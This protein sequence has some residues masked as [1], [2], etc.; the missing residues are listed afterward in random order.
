MKVLC[1]IAE[2]VAEYVT[3]PLCHLV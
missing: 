3:L 2:Y 1:L